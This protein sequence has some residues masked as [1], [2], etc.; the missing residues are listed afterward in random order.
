[1]IRNWISPNYDARPIGTA[2]DMLVLHYTGM[3]SGH[4][5]LERLCDPEAEVSAH[6]LSEENGDLFQLV[7]EEKRAWHAGV[8]NWRGYE[9]LNQ[10]S[11]GIELVNT[12]HE[13]GYRPFP[14]EQIE[15]LVSLIRDIRSRHE[16]DDRMIVGHSDIAPDRKEDPG[17]L[18]PWGYLAE[19]GIGWV[20]KGSF[21]ST[22]DYITP[23]AATSQVIA[24]QK[25]LAA[26]GYN[27]RSDGLYNSTLTYCVTAFQRRWRQYEVT[28]LMDKGT[29]AALLQVSKKC[30][31]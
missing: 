20:P 30:D 5:A 8:S 31:T 17:E 9:G 15:T 22:E 26:I 21:E 13:F 14:V 18:F 7:K 29:Y 23:L 10:H 25:R 4:Q 12:G 28:G 24:V 19:K 2:I 1:M 16:I 3:E 11:I 6:Y 27:I